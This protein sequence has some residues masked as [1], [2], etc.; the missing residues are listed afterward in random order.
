MKCGRDNLILGLPWLNKINPKIDWEKK[1]IKINDATDQTEAYNRARFANQPT[2]RTLA[3][4]PTYPDLLPT[5]YEKE[6]PF[7]PD[8][9]FHNYVRGVENVHMKGTG[10]YIKRNGKLVPMVVAKTSISGKLA[11]KSGSGRSLST[12]RIPGIRRSLLRR[13]FPEDATKTGI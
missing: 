12:R 13:G 2:I 1:S 8:E 6:S 10:R 7:Y 5:D 11:Q 9:N 3:E 4:E